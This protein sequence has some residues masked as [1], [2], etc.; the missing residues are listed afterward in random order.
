MGHMGLQYRWALIYLTPP[1]NSMLA[2]G[3]RAVVIFYTDRPKV[4]W[5]LKSVEVSYLEV[6]VVIFCNGCKCT[7]VLFNTFF[8][9]QWNVVLHVCFFFCHGPT[10]PVKKKQETVVLI[11][12]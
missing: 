7:E 3:L 12:T 11:Q 9:M 6:T 1:S 10:V 8:L 2:K 4:W 5:P